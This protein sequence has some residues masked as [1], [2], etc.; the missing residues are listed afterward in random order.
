MVSPLDPPLVTTAAAVL[1]GIRTALTSV[2]VLVLL[3][4]YVGIGALAHDLGFSLWW[5]LLSTALVWAAP[6]QVIAMSALASGARLLEIAIAVSLSGVRLLPMVVTLMPLLRARGASAWRLVLPAHFVAVNIW[7]LGQQHGPHIPRERRVAFVN[8]MGIGMAVPACAATV[9]GFYLAAT[10]PALLNAALLF[11]TP[12][13]FLIS[14]ARTSRTLSD[15]V[16]IVLGLVI[17]PVLAASQVDLD[18]L[19]TGIGGGTLAYV[20][21][22]LQKAWT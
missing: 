22:R 20:A 15:G 18:L 5:V 16:A 19:W 4:T 17:A 8:G 10:L 2:L 7:I 6:A 14:I 12:L 21:Q 3:G 11:L 13:S 9:F 1:A